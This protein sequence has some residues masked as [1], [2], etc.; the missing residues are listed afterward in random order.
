MDFGVFLGERFEF[1]AVLGAFFAVFE[2]PEPVFFCFL[3]VFLLFSVDLPFWE[4]FLPLSGMTRQ[5][6]L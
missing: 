3:V 4:V 1:F 6:P 2:D 5:S